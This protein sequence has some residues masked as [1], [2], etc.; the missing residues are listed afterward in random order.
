MKFLKLIAFKLHQTYPFFLCYSQIS[1][2]KKNTRFFLFLKEILLYTYQDINF[3]N[4]IPTK[5]QPDKMLH[6][7]TTLKVKYFLH[8]NVLTDPKRK[9]III[10]KQITN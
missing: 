8:F 9:K 2:I 7:K 6:K 4:G 3:I 1:N 5:V 10:I